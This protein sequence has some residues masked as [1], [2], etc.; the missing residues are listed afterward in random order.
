MRFHALPK[1]I[2]CA[3]GFEPRSVRSLLFLASFLC[4]PKP[5]YGTCLSLFPS[6]CSLTQDGGLSYYSPITA[7]HLL[8][9]CL[10]NLELP[11]P[12]PQWLAQL[13]QHREQCQLPWFSWGEKKRRK[14]TSC[15][16]RPLA[17]CHHLLLFII[18][19]LRAIK[20]IPLP[21][22]P[23]TIPVT[24]RPGGLFSVTRGP[25]TYSMWASVTQKQ[26]LEFIK[27]FL[28]STSLAPPLQLSDMVINHTLNRNS[29]SPWH[30]LSLLP[31]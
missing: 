28:N 31:L 13:W 26:Q 22:L 11:I 19:S 4:D 18:Q 24:G 3:H 12:K 27:Y 5:A 29:F 10:D 25:R 2:V 7:H 23:L 14:S 15:S 20:P 1:I 30:M 6:N 21:P 17:S 16:Q 8:P 9:R